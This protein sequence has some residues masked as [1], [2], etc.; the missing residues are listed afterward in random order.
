MGTTEIGLEAPGMITPEARGRSQSGIP[1]VD[2][3]RL[4]A[5]VIL[6]CIG[7]VLVAQSTNQNIGAQL[8]LGGLYG[9]VFVLA[10]ANR[11]TTAGAGLLWGLGYAFVLWLAGP[12]GLFTLGTSGGQ[13]GQLDLAQQHFPVLVAYIV[14]F[15][16]PLGLSQGILSSLRPTGLLAAEREQERERGHFSVARA[17]MV[18]GVSGLIAGWFFA[19]GP[20]V[21]QA[22]FFV[23]VAGLLNSNSYW[24]G[25]AVHYLIALVIGASFGLL[26]QRDIRGFGSSLG[27]G[28]GYGLFWWFLGPLTLLSILRGKAVDWS[29]NHAASDALFGSLVSHIIYG[30]LLGLIY[31]ALNRL[32]VGFFYDSDPINRQPEGA[33][34]VALRSLGWGALASLTGGLLFSLVMNATG[35]LPSVAA[36]V[37]GTSPLLGFAVH[38]VIS[39][40]I[41]M[42]YGLL[43]KHEAPDVGSGIAWGLLYGLAWWFLGPLTLFPIL[44]GH[45]ATWTV[46]AA[47]LALPSLAGHL[48]YGAAT[49]CTFLVLE[50]RHDAWIALDPRI[51]AREKRL[52]RP[53]GT[54]APA[55]WLFVLGLGVLLPVLLG[56][57]PHIPAIPSY[58]Y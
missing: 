18:G 43:F 45:M 24:L 2:R 48:I 57:M 21:S 47:S 38:L 29:Y 10:S 4:G 14:L 5:G 17:L 6:G 26:F 52:R 40:L 1:G 33:G 13:I 3:Y 42:T 50:R 7:G 27:W 36:L 12:A 15:G 20:W 55:L 16:L 30:L 9:L 25:V 39:A 41:G 53:V 54:P 11:A 22:N 37:G 34:A 51:A 46:A 58:S 35:E 49:A 28:F 32:W 19:R 23:T 56:N 44:L 31:A 8:V